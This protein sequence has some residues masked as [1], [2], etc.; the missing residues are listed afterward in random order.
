MGYFKSLKTC[1]ENLIFFLF[2]AKRYKVALV[3]G[4]RCKTFH[5][6]ELPSLEYRPLC[7]LSCTWTKANFIFWCLQY[8]NVYRGIKEGRN[9]RKTAPFIPSPCSNIILSLL[10]ISTLATLT[11]NFKAFSFNLNIF[12]NETIN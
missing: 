9:W 2:I 5:F 11:N 3:G 8:F 1:L 7:V 4:L 12:I 10:D 6:H